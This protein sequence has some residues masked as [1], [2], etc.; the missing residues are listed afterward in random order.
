M[1]SYRT[2]VDHF[3]AGRYLEAGSV[4]VEGFDVPVG[5]TPSL[6]V[7]PLDSDAI[8][9]FWNAL[10]GPLLS[11]AEF[12][13]PGGSR[14]SN[15]AKPV[16]AVYWRK[17]NNDSFQLTGAGSSLGPRVF[18]PLFVAPPPPVVLPVQTYFFEAGQY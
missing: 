1:A 2:L 12:G 18:R 11:D 3:V 6:S 17:I 5:W 10:P 4:I 14:F 7:D 16:P 9:K 15:V 13:W 8:Q